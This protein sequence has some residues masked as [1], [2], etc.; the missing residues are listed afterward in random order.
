MY[1][2]TAQ[3]PLACAAPLAKPESF[4][5]IASDYE[6]KE[7]RN[8]LRR[9]LRAQKAK[10]YHAKKSFLDG[11]YSTNLNSDT[12]IDEEELKL[13]LV[14]WPYSESNSS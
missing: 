12:N 7:K 6:A 1:A 4:S 8:N 10:T 9:S 14:W 13:N 3:I 11:S 2:R 5:D